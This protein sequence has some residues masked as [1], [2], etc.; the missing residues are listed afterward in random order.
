MSYW[1]SMHEFMCKLGYCES[2]VFF[3]VCV[4]VEVQTT[5]TFSLSHNCDGKKQRYEIWTKHL[6]CCGFLICIAVLDDQYSDYS[7]INT[8]GRTRPAGRVFTSDFPLSHW[9]TWIRPISLSL[10][11]DEDMKTNIIR[12]PNK[13]KK[14]LQSDLISEDLQC[15]GLFRYPIFWNK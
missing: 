12:K 15:V 6:G 7:K 8:L 14:K 1:Q 3:P 2:M 4:N 5:V 11:P 13:T 9:R 10:C